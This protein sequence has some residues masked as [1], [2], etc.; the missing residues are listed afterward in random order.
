MTT[1]STKRQPAMVN[2][3]QGVAVTKLASVTLYTDPIPVTPKIIE[4]FKLKTNRVVY[5]TG[6]MGL[7]DIQEHDIMTV[8]GVDYLVQYVGKVTSPVQ[9]TAVLMELQK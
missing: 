6:I 9:Y 2:G 1:A 8:A 4:E 7:P 5:G 3:K